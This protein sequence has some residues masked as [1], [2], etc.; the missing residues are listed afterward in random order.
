MA[1]YEYTMI[2]VATKW[3]G[4]AVDREKTA[5]RLNELAREGWE[6]DATTINWWTTADLV[7]RRAR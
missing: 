3:L 5:R 7:L 2:P 1:E 4:L 6:L